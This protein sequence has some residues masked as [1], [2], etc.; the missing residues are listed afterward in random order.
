MHLS[1]FLSLHTPP[2]HTL[3]HLSLSTYASP[4]LSRNL[5]IHLPF[6]SFSPSLFPPSF[7]CFFPSIQHP[8]LLLFVWDEVLL[9]TP[10]WLG[11]HYAR[12]PLTMAVCLSLTSS[13]IIGIRHM[14]DLMTILT[15]FLVHSETRK[16]SWEFHL[17]R[18]AIVPCSQR[19]QVSPG[20]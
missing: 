16:C 6:N 7:S 13:G 5:S 19:Q 10:G 20:R 12:W 8:F 17:C 14:S 15:M 1:I 18:Q 4:S 9:C 2:I 3:I 11:T